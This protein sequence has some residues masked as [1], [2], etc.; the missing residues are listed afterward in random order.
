MIVQPVKKYRMIAI[1]LI[2]MVCL[3]VTNLFAGWVI[4]EINQNSNGMMSMQSTFIQRDMV[5]IETNETIIILDLQKEEICLI[6]P[7]RMVYW[8]GNPS[9]FKE[10]MVQTV[11]SQIV[12]LIEQ[13]PFAEREANRKEM[14]KIISQMR[15]DSVVQWLPGKLMLSETGKS[16]T[17]AGHLSYCYEIYIDS[18]LYEKVWVSNSVNP[19]AGIDLTRMMAMTRELTSPTVIGAYRESEEYLGLIRHGFVMKSVLSTPLGESTTKVE[20][21]RNIEIRPEIFLPPIEYRPAG[22]AEILQMTLHDFD[23]IKPGRP[24]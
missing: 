4:V 17:I 19:F 20:S 6:Y 8:K 1:T 23:Q 5:R 12:T 21:L 3:P 18:T 9:D 2:L 14:D 10:S 15:S 24:E 16:D 7:T 22:L 13:L 11:E